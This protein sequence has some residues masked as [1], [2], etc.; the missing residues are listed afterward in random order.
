[1]SVIAY[2]LLNFH[3]PFMALILLL[4]LQ[5]SVELNE[6]PAS[7]PTV[8]A[9]QEG[10]PPLQQGQHRPTHAGSTMTATPTT[11][12]H[13]AHGNATVS[14]PASRD[15]PSVVVPI[16]RSNQYHSPGMTNVNSFETLE[17]P[18]QPEPQASG[19][20]VISG[21]ASLPAAQQHSGGST[22]TPVNQLSHS[23]ES[24]SFG[25]SAVSQHSTPT[26]PEQP[27]SPQPPPLAQAA[28]LPFA[29]AVN[30][31][32]V[33]VGR[34]QQPHDDSPKSSKYG[35]HD[36][37]HGLLSSFYSSMHECV[38]VQIGLPLCYTFIQ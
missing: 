13:S 15:S 4:I 29:A 22:A 20:S 11:V 32:P 31:Q 16:P 37:V 23:S 35:D 14:Q 2:F 7:M 24:L 36:C 10:T 27:R 34:D 12:S 26:P 6:P 8:Q 33:G 21:G 9:V 38:S 25:S 1:M 5:S 19:R 18:S 28:A 30:A 17:P 3:C